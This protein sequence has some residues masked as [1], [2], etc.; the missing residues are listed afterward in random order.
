MTDIN[1]IFSR[2]WEIYMVISNRRTLTQIVNIINKI[3]YWAFVYTE[4]NLSKHNYKLHGYIIFQQ[5]QNQNWLKIY[6]GENGTYMD[7]DEHP[8]KYRKRA[9]E[10][11]HVFADESDA[12]IRINKG[13]YKGVALP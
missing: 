12:V 7:T 1:D 2:F 11:I 8:N 10:T 4:S 13:L 6:L 3:S 5:P 9:L